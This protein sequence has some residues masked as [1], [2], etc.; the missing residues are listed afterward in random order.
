MHHGSLFTPAPPLLSPWALFI[1]AAASDMFSKKLHTNIDIASSRGGGLISVFPPIPIKCTSSH[2]HIPNQFRCPCL[3]YIQCHIASQ[4]L[5]RVAS[6]PPGNKCLFF[7]QNHG[8]LDL[9]STK[10]L[11]SLKSINCRLVLMVWQ[12]NTLGIDNV[13]GTTAAP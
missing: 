8:C 9:H 6:L 4:G 13:C 10:S 3:F 2:F 1:A 12:G 7:G 11:T 5:I